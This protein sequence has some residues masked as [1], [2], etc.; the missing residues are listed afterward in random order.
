MAQA[1]AVLPDRGLR[2]FNANKSLNTYRLSSVAQRVSADAKVPAGVGWAQ[3]SISR[4]ATDP[5]KKLPEFIEYDLD[6]MNRWA[7][8]RCGSSVRIAN[9]NCP[10]SPRGFEPLLP[11]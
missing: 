11:P 9:V 1:A 3:I 2:D 7:A 5:L 10:A 4:D 8:H 6:D